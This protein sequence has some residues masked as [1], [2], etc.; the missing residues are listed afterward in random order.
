[1]K[2][3][4]TVMILLAMSGGAYAQSV[5]SLVVDRG[6]EL[7]SQYALRDGL[8]HKIDSL[9]LLL[10]DARERY[11]SESEN[12]DQIV[13]LITAAESEY[14]KLRKQHKSLCQSIDKQESEQL[15]EQMAQQRENSPEQQMESQEVD[16]YSMPSSRTLI[17]NACFRGEL[18]NEDYQALVAAHQS[19]SAASAL[20]EEFARLYTELIDYNNL[21]HTVSD[22]SSADQL[23]DKINSTLDSCA[24]VDAQLDT[25]WGKIFDDKSYSYSYF[26]ERMGFGDMLDRHID[27]LSYA[28]READAMI[29]LY[30]SDALS[31]YI[32][33]KRKLVDCERDIASRMGFSEAL[34]SLNREVAYLA[35]IDYA[36]P[37]IEI[38]RKYLLEYEGVGFVSK[39]KYTSYNIPKVVVYD[40]GTIYRV[41]LGGYRSRQQVSIFK[42]VTPLYIQH[43]GGQ[44]CYYT[45]GFATKAEARLAVEILR[46]KGFKNPVVVEWADGVRRDVP[47]SEQ[48]VKYRLEITGVATLPDGVKSVV[49]A[50]SP[51]CEIARVGSTYMVASFVDRA[52]ADALARRIREVDPTLKVE[53]VEME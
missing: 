4:F 11:R 8:K 41:R 30:A 53:V 42:G 17:D 45:G 22:Q 7:E 40:H 14:L 18:H 44:Y 52:I 46:K 36:L 49:N 38:E 39:P 34:D 25:V 6:V 37:K 13:G 50:Q 2:R 19:E 26:M 32:I 10:D 12:R 20:V 43:D 33:Q 31:T 5:D 48:D 35:S 23:Y 29:G 21:Y 16:Y 24:E 1:M 47:D 51:K 27:S 28:Q 3:L 9:E 15:L